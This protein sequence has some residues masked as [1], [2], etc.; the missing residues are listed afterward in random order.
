MIL[1][2]TDASTWRM[3][4]GLMAFGMLIGA[5]ATLM[6]FAGRSR[7]SK[8]ALGRVQ[9]SLIAI[10]AFLSSLGF[11]I[12]ATVMP[13]AALAN[14]A[15]AFHQWFAIAQALFVPS[16]SLF[17][18]GVA[19]LASFEFRS[20]LPVMPKWSC[21]VAALVAAFVAVRIPVSVLTRDS[22]LEIVYGV[23][24]LPMVWLFA[25]GQRLMLK[26]IAGRVT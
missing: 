14:N 23:S 21:L 8:G 17:L 6:L 2:A 12:E 15:S 19:L 22:S 25:F 18:V 16:F 1:I 26:K 7:W 13:D 9:C 5:I 11:I 4:H 10:F 20:H 3:N 24:L